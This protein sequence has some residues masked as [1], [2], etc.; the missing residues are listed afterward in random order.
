MASTKMT[1]RQHAKVMSSIFLHHLA[2]LLCLASGTHSIG[3]PEVQP[4]SF[5]KNIALGQK[6]VVNCGA[7]SGDGPFEFRWV[8]DGKELRSTASKYVKTAS[9][10]IAT[11][12]IERVG[13]EDVGNYTCS[14]SNAVGQDSFTAALAVKGIEIT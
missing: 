2:H 12:V 13:A 6:A 11:L 5:S 14:V 3:P 8:Q 7:V 10:T 4:F 9:E 1:R